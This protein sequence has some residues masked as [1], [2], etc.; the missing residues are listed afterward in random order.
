M[1]LGTS[2]QY[3]LFKHSVVTLCLNLFMTSAPEIDRKEIR[4]YYFRW[5]FKRNIWL[6]MSSI[7]VDWLLK[8]KNLNWSKIYQ[9]WRK[10]IVPRF[11]FCQLL[12]SWNGRELAGKRGPTPRG[13]KSGP[14]PDLLYKIKCFL[15]GPFPG[16][17]FLY[18]VFSIQLTVNKCSI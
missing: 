18:F 1:C 4:V 9:N 3:M 5:C 13:F 2:H 15:N 6:M 11:I 17:I 8:V 16:L 12:F 14:H 10:Q 7:D